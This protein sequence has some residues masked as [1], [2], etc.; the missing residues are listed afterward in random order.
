MSGLCKEDLTMYLRLDCKC[1]MCTKRDLIM[2]LRLVYMCGMCI[3]SDM[4]CE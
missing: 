2:Y 4:L 1:D 3:E